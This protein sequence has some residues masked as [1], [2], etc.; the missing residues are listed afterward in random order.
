M[1]SEVFAEESSNT[2]DFYK[3]IISRMMN[4][5]ALHKIILDCEGKPCDYEFIDVNPSFEI[6][7]GLKKEDILGRKVSEIIPN[8]REDEVDWIDIYGNVATKG[9]SISF[10]SFSNS[11]GKWY[12]VN[13]YSP[14]T[15]YFVTAFNDISQMKRNELDLIEKNEELFETQEKLQHLAC[16][17]YLTGL[18]NRVS[19]YKNTEMK[20]QEFPSSNMAL[21]FIDSD[22]FK[23]INGTLGHSFG[24]KFVIEI[25]NR[26]SSLFH[27]D[28][29][30]YR[31]DGA[32]FILFLYG[33]VC[34]D[35]VKECAE[36]IIQ[37]F[38]TPFN[39]E[40]NKLHTTVSIGIAIYPEQGKSVEELLKNA[41]IAMNNAKEVGKN[42]FVFYNEDLR[43]IVT[44]KLLIEKHLYTALENHEFEI[45]YQPQLDLT[46][47]EI[48]GFEA[49][50]R[51]HNPELGFVSP[52]VFIEV[53]EYT[54]LII[55]IGK[56]VLRNACYFI[57]KLQYKGHTDFTVAVNVSVIQLIQED[58]VE[59]VLATIDL[60]DLEPKYL[61]IEITESILVE[62]Y[63]A[64]FKKLECLRE[65]GIKIS[66][67]D[68]GKGYSSLSG[69]QNLPIDTLKVDKIF[70]DSI[71][72]Q[73][74]RICITDMIIMLGRKMG[75]TVLA[76]GVETQEQMDYL[77][78]NQCHR[79][80]GYLFSKPIPEK[81]I[82]NML[83][84]K[85]EANTYIYG[86]EWKDEYSVNI[87][88][89][90]SQHKKMFEIGNRLSEMIYSKES[91]N[92]GAEIL[93]I[94]K[95][96]EKY[97]ENHFKYEENYMLMHGYI[98]FDTHLNEH[99]AFISK[100]IKANNDLK[101]YM[102]KDYFVYLIDMVSVWI[103]NHILKEDMKF[104]DF[105]SE[106]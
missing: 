24:E 3:T 46:T 97:T 4:A 47:K 17:D 8:I 69:L 58:F 56:W 81:Q 80:Q 59:T 20:L 105:L 23:F 32:E 100:V 33:F 94:L 86:F 92:D 77:I 7:T 74:E 53:A 31:L 9:T 96:L 43:N 54:H 41:N 12:I 60:M 26:L 2:I 51:W 14:K 52:L 57:K 28:H 49:L 87:D 103:T 79:M 65:R 40:G 66:L 71:L 35:E 106:K 84:A 89:I 91:F 44:E 88:S 30:L 82:L 83:S 11:L 13:A 50:L 55:P 68:F 61:E 63:E 27:N 102:E 78:E 22:N 101:N 72:N 67:D 1:S 38:D 25:G 48:C 70:I 19:F 95:E 99:K 42:R 29:K 21:F 18:P 90:D 5:Y 36:R 98:F 16:H 75:M 93:T 45:Y 76:E 37:C 64:I 39:L 10:D 104:R 73:D 15:D 62:S 6:L 85:T 34:D